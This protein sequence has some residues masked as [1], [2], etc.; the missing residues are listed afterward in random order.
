MRDNGYSLRSDFD[1]KFRQSE[2][3]EKGLRSA[4]LE[5]RPREFFS[6]NYGL[7][8]TTPKNKKD[9]YF[10]RLVDY[11]GSI[12]RPDLL[13]FRN[14][15]AQ[16]VKEIVYQYGTTS[17]EWNYE[18]NCVPESELKE[19]LGLATTAIEVEY[20]GWKAQDMPAF[21]KTLRLQRRAATGK[22]PDGLLGLGSNPG[23]L[24][25]VIVKE[26]DRIKLNAWDSQVLGLTGKKVPIHVWH[27]FYNSLILGV[28]FDAIDRL[29]DQNLIQSV[30]CAKI[31]NKEMYKVIHHYCYR[32]V[33]I[34]K[35]PTKR[36]DYVIR[37]NGRVV[38]VHWLVGG[39][40]ELTK[41][42]LQVLRNPSARW[43]VPKKY[44]CKKHQNLK[45][46]V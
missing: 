44:I 3:G 20:S 1:E 46:V 29:I 41:D 4:I 40:M 5:H 7:S 18:M 13:V 39:K 6:L 26:E 43:T 23:I 14:K 30:E 36:S 12:K 28:Q 25:H 16:A 35:S 27:V 8:G 9:V 24:P 37:N 11:R 45:F 2:W 38:P 31:D 10:E 33:I 19:L 22:L 42:G 15:D 21:G 32:P 34:S 17:K